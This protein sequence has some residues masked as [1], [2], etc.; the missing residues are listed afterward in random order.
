MTGVDKEE[1]PPLLPAGLHSL[2]VNGRRRLCVERF[3][4][5]VTRPRII[6]NL[7]N[8]II[9]IN[10]QG[11]MGQIWIDGS[12]L[13]EKLNPDDVD[14]ALVLLRST[15]QSLSVDQRHF[16]D[17]FR[18]TSRY[19]QYKIDNYGIVLEPAQATD[20]W[21]YAYWLRQFGFS[22]VLSPPNDRTRSGISASSDELTG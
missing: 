8:T 18:R 3:G 16:F 4:D 11:I 12:F 21:M 17:N 7:E 14:V 6:S 2:D 19:D 5:S 1:F 15:Y 20:Q 13:T 22:R 9:E 10:R